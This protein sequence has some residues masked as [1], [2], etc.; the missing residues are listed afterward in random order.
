MVDDGAFSYKIGHPNGITGSRVTAIFAEWVDFE[1]W[2][3]FSGGRSA[4][5]GATPPSFVLISH[6]L[7]Y[8]IPWRLKVNRKKLLIDLIYSWT[9]DFC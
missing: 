1:H 2:W 5:N 4:I 7:L 3:S 9:L 8:E 6:S